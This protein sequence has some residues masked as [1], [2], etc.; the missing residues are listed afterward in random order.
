VIAEVDVLGRQWQ[1]P[2]SIGIRPD[3]QRA[4]DARQGWRG[5]RTAAHPA[6]LVLAVAGIVST[7]SDRRTADGLA[8]VAVAVA[9]VCD[10]V[11]A[12]AA[13]GRAPAPTQAQAPAS[14][15]DRLVVGVTC[16]LA[17]LVIASFQRYSWPATTAVRALAAVAVIDRWRAPRVG[18]A[19]HPLPRAGTLAWVAVLIAAGLWELAALLGQPTLTTGSWDHPTISVLTDPA[20]ATYPGR[21][22]ILTLW[23]AS[24]WYLCRKVTR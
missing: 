18:P 17:A 6:T 13:A 11:R 9:L 2:G 23:L 10:A 7:L 15:T 12:P 1:V 20:L 3:R 19:A 14:R 21:A 8:L 5:L 22:V 24:G 4:A 16:I